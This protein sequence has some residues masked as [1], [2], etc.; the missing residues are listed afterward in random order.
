MLDNGLLAFLAFH[1]ITRYVKTV[2]DIKCAKCKGL[3]IIKLAPQF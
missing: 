2:Y 1:V 3:P